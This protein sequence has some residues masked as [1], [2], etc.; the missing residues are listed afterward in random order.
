MPAKIKTC[1]PL[2]WSTD[3][4]IDY[5]AP[6]LPLRALLPVVGEE[7]SAFFERQ[8]RIQVG[9]TLQLIWCPPVADLNGWNEQPSEIALSH[10]LR[11]R[12]SGPAPEPPTPRNAL[13]QGKLRYR[14][15]VLSC[16]P[17][18]AALRAQPL[19]Q[20]AWHLPL[21]ESGQD[22]CL[23][24]EAIGECHRAEVQGLIYLSA[25]RRHETYMELFIEEAD[26][27][28][29]GLFSVHLGP[30]GN[31][32]EFGRRLLEGAELQAIRRALEIALPLKDSQPAYLSP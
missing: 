31:D 28:L 26:E 21:I 25:Y 24:W 29:F 27:Q 12:I 18:P 17:L 8:D 6:T 23:T 11:V 1:A 32:Y 5:G 14:F 30:G 22:C 15:R 3:L 2:F 9:E 16:Q 19:E 7:S 10:L 20:H 13:Y 4:G